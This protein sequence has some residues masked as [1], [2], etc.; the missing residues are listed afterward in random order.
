MAMMAMIDFSELIPIYRAAGSIDDL[1]IE[2]C[3]NTEELLNAVVLIRD[4]E[5]AQYDSGISLLE[6]AADLQLGRKIKVRI[7]SPKA[8]LGYLVSNFS[9]YLGRRKSKIKEREFFLK[10]NLYYSRD[11]NPPVVVSSY[12]ST[13]QLLRLLI[14]AAHYL[15]KE[16]ESLIFYKD[17][18]FEIPIS[19]TTDEMSALS[20]ASLEKLEEIVLD[21]IHLEAKKE[22]L[23][24]TIVDMVKDISESKRFSYLM[25]N[26]PDML[27]RFQV[28]Y[29]LF[30]ADFSYEKAEDEVNKFKLDIIG[31][32]HKAISDI[33]TQLLGIPIAAF[34]A[35]TQ[36][37]L[38]GHLGAQFAINSVILLGVLVFCALLGGLT[39]NQWLTLSSIEEEVRR[40][41]DIFDARFSLTSS[42][43]KGAFSEVNRRLGFQFLA[44]TLILVLN[45]SVVLI[46]LIYYIVHTRPI[47]QV[48]F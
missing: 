26:L 4:D 23:A 2:L 43:Y 10:D 21:L 45:A 7:Q 34:V 32:L 38:T 28:A 8:S 16:S 11:V 6:S 9:D 13:L 44:L 30:S 5:T 17:G 14:E 33:Q 48:F 41:Y 24:K 3:V 18:R 25:A 31:R 39:F 46:A 29:N 19:Y 35:L 20:L 22:L 12:R 36:M 27:A 47:Y 1:E 40:Q 15:D 42:A 37:K